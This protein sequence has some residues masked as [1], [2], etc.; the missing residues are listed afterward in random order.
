MAEAVFAERVRAA[1]LAGQIAVDSA[2]TSGWHAGETAHQG[3]LAVLR[4]HNIPYDGRSRALTR[5]DLDGFDYVLTMDNA[6]YQ[7][8]QRMMTPGSRATLAMFLSFAGAE[9]ATT[10][11][12]VPDPYYHDNFDEVYALVTTGADA[13]LRKLR[14]DHDL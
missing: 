3:T 7:S 2:G 5:A 8:V 9:G 10:V 13:L 6:N 11:T 4:R 14:A 1:G 12:E